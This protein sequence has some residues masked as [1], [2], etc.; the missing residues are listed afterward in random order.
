MWVRLGCTEIAESPSYNKVVKLSHETL[1]EQL[2]YETKKPSFF[3]FLTI[4]DT[5]KKVSAM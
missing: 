1:M 4:A 5:E 2:R 3:Q